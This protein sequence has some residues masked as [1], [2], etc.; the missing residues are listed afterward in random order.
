MGPGPWLPLVA[1]TAAMAPGIVGGTTWPWAVL[2]VGVVAIIL[3]VATAIAIAALL[4][5]GARAV[6]LARMR[7]A[8]LASPRRTTCGLST[9]SPA[10]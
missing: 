4:A 3:A 2:V 8:R 6:R 7:F 9:P 5:G 10:P 1:I